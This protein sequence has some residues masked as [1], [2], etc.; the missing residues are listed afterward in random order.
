MLERERDTQAG[1]ELKQLRSLESTAIAGSRA[2]QV[3]QLG[4]LPFPRCLNVSIRDPQG[5]L[6]GQGHLYRISPAF[7]SQHNDV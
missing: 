4:H 1:A 7:P 3:V 6:Q 2:L 5:A